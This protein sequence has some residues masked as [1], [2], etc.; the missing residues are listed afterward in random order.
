MRAEH[1]TPRTVAF[2]KYQTI[3]EPA[4]KSTAELIQFAIKNYFVVAWS[5]REIL[6]VLVR[7]RFGFDI[8]FFA[9][10]KKK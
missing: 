3:E 10:E 4:L 7:S 8:Y 5:S 2:H 6:I 9:R 1:V